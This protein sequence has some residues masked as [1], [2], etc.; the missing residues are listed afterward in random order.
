MP[1][2]AAVLS[3]IGGAAQSA[4]AAPNAPSAEVVKWFQTTE[5]A[6]MDSLASGDK[7]AWERVMDPAC[8]VTSEEG[9]VT[10]RQQFLDE[11]RPLPEGLAGG[12]A[13]QELTVQEF[14]S[15][16]VVRYLADEWESVFGQRLSVK[17]RVTNTYR[18]DGAD[19]K[20]VASH[21]AVVT[22]DPPAQA[23]SGAGWP[24][25]VGSYRLLPAGWTLTV[26]LR[27]G[28]LYAGRD[29]KKL[30][31]LVPLTP[32]AFVLSGSLG[33]WLFVVENDKATRIVNLRKFATLVWTRVVDAS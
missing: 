15:F 27:D 30:K 5:Q 4:V 32:D 19:W 2:A 12:I 26:E 6:L 28:K 24:A 13:V 7:A 33:E 22:Q 3:L 17:Y 21:L 14:P 29:P 1:Y 10:G 9:Q 11:V 25:L 8:V 18:R 16:A 31:P 20:M 23:V